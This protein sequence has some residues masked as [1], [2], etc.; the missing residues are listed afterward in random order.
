MLSPPQ[1]VT[2]GLPFFFAYNG[3]VSAISSATLRRDLSERNIYRANEFRHELSY[4]PIPSV[5]YRGDGRSHGN[6]YPSSYRAICANPNWKKRLEKRYTGSKWVP[7][8]GEKNRSELDCA[9]SSDALLMN[10]FCYPGIVCKPRVCSLLGVEPGLLPTFGF[11]PRIP[12]LNKLGDQTEVDMKIGDLLVEAKLTE[13][14]FQ[15]RPSRLLCRYRDLQEVFEVSELPSKGET[16]RGYQLVRGVLAAYA[17]DSS[18]L[19]ICDGRRTDLVHGWFEIIRAVRSYSFRNRLKLLT[20]QE[21][22]EILPSRL[23]QFLDEKYGLS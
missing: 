16:V 9:N 10:I 17:L 13:S 7:W 11:R 19:L 8:S 22:A 2:A 20:W 18:F 3:P 21:I 14:G 12:L 5:I 1:K 6:F 15:S 23:R 4:G